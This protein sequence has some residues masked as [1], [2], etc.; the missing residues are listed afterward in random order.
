M[1]QVVDDRGQVTG[2]MFHM[3]LGIVLA[4]FMG[5]LK[6]NPHMSRDLVSPVHR[7]F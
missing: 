1:L 7:I 5:F 3:T 6:I 4:T 2:D